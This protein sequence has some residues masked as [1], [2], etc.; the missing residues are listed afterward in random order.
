MPFLFMIIDNFIYLSRMYCSHVCM[1]TNIIILL[2]L[3]LVLLKC[4]GEQLW[5]SVVSPVDDSSVSGIVSI[6]VEA[7]DAVTSV[8]FYIDDSCKYVSHAA[9]FFYV[10]NT[11]FLS[12]SSSHVIYLVAE[13][14]KG[15]EVCSDTVLVM[16]DNADTVFADGFELYL[17]GSYPHAGWFEIWLGAGSDHTYVEQGN[18]NSGLQ[19]FRLRGTANWV[20]TDGVELMLGNIHQL[21]YEV[22]LMIPSED[23]TGALFGFFVL[24]N[25]TLGTI[26]NGVWFSYQDNLV[27]ARGAVE[28]S[29]GFVW[30]CDTWYRVTVSV[31][32]VQQKMNVWLDNE[33]VVF[34]LPATP[35]DLTDTFALATEYGSAG[36]VYY[37]DIKVFED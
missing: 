11:F 9:P 2:L 16:V 18:T 6:D 20:R 28:D 31:N 30:V 22:A 25:P 23:A 7:G 32:Y 5:V 4:G 34:D 26:Y 8:A 1:K 27:Y 19:S 12:D 13:D 33:Q 14:R 35:L 15:D 37:D 24:L 29:T 21:T 3:V 36:I 10:W 17:P